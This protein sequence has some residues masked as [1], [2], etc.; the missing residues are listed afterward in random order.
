MENTESNYDIMARQAQERFL[1]FDQQ[2]IIRKFQ[3]RSDSE[4]IYLSFSGSPYRISRSD[5]A[6]YC[7]DGSSA[8]KAG[9]NEALS[10]YDMLCCPTES[11]S[12]SGIWESISSLG[13]IIGAGHSSST[14]LSRRGLPFSGKTE[15]L[16]KACLSLGGRPASSGDVSFILPVFD[17]F[18]VWFQFWDG[19]DEF[20]PSIRFLWD[21]N[22]FQYLHYETL[23]YIMN[24]ILDKL[25]SML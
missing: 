21:R 18:P 20:P 22:T 11:P 13:G 10:I 16:S 25:Q 8:R 2:P 15:Q 24:H 17:F 14:M 9:F 1:T 5:G 7:L 6:I 4:S 19:D 23:W 12:L 3:L